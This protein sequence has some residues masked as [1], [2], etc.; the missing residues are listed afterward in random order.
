MVKCESG[1]FINGD[2]CLKEVRHKEYILE[3][4]RGESYKITKRNDKRFLK[5]VVNKRHF[6]N[7]KSLVRGYDEK[8]KIITCDDITVR[9]INLDAF[10]DL[11]PERNS[12]QYNLLKSVI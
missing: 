11:S 4:K 6:E 2:V 7:I 5:G 10:W 1:L 9:L 8:T 3:R 12:K